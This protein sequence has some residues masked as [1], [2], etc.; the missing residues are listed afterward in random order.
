MGIIL[1]FQFA[2]LVNQFVDLT[3]EKPMAAGAIADAGGLSFLPLTRPFRHRSP[4][5]ARLVR[6]TDAQV[7]EGN[8][9]GVAGRRRSSAS[10]IGTPRQ[11][12]GEHYPAGGDG[13][14]LLRRF[15]ISIQVLGLSHHGEFSLAK[16]RLRSPEE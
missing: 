12:A 8:V 1:L 3:P 2:S 11:Q 16:L 13:V 14:R 6:A 4:T 15:P 5:R 7:L 10:R 9:A